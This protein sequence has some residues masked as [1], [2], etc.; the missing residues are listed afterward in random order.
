MNIEDIVRSGL[1]DAADQVA[2]IPDLHATALQRGRRRRTTRRIATAGCVVVSVSAIIATGVAVSNGTGGGRHHNLH[3][4]GQGDGTQQVVADP[5][6]DTWSTDRYDG[7]V[8]P[9]FLQAIRP[10]YDT[11][12]GPEKITVYAAGTTSDGNQWAM[13]TD[14]TEGH[15]IE[16]WQGRNNRPL[17]GEVPPE[18]DA[19]QT[20]TSW[21]M[22]TE[23]AENGSSG[24]QQ[25]LIVVGRPGTTDID[26]SP[27]GATWRPLETHNGIAVTFFADGFPP[28]SARVR[29]SDASG[30]YATGKP[31]GAGAGESPSASPLP[32]GSSTSSPTPTA[33]PSSITASA[34]AA[35][36]SATR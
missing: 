6:W 1:H 26:F 3:V 35:P 36:P 11:S 4:A 9:A 22:P 14:P 29:L 33:A 31:A 15:R 19:G 34:S 2:P 30:V 27:D 32:G 18:V 28:A 24:N 12:K 20:W 8:D 25:W 10:T 21:S 7:H 5:W 16:W 13:T 17:V 23:S